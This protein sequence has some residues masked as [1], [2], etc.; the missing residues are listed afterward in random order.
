MSG[1]FPLSAGTRQIQTILVV[2][3]GRRPGGNE[4]SRLYDLLQ[5]H[6][7]GQDIRDMILV[8]GGRFDELPLQNEGLEVTL[9]ILAG[10][11]GKSPVSASSNKSIFMDED[12]DPSPR[13]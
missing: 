6:R 9:R 8:S 1:I 13:T 5:E 11:L 4:G 10:E 7:K 3:N 12:E 2:L